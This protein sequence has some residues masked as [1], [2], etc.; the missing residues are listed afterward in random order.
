MIYQTWND[1]GQSER[2][3]ITKATPTITA[4]SRWPNLA[5]KIPF[6]YDNLEK[7][8]ADAINEAEKQGAKVVDY[9]EKESADELDYTAIRNE[10]YELWTQLIERDPANA[11]IIA[12]KVEMIFGRKLKLSEITEDQVSLFELVLSEMKELV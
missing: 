1:E 2:W 12:K 11:E 3:L 9:V 10:A 6:G 8:I 5:P 4:G 7:A